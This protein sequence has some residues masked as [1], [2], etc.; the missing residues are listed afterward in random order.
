MV[1]LA[2]FRCDRSVYG[3]LGQSHFLGTR[4]NAGYCF[5][6]FRIRAIRR[7]WELFVSLRKN[8]RNQTIERVRIVSR[9]SNRL[10]AAHFQSIGLLHHMI[11]RRKKPNPWRGRL[12][13]FSDF[14]A[15]W[16]W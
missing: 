16:P 14:L 13:R 5:L 9:N 15:F 12:R 8:I 10:L 7:R 1:A 6:L 11:F 2:H 3:C 4:S